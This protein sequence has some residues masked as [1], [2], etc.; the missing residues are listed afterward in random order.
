MVQCTILR[1]YHHHIPK[2]IKNRPIQAWVIYFPSSDF[3][4][5]LASTSHELISCSYYH[6]EQNISDRAWENRSYAHILYFEKYKFE[7]LNALHFSCGTVQL[8]QM[9]SVIIWLG[10]IL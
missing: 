3:H 4:I 7:I 9:Y 8:R 10:I 6:Q 1:K 5:N 2:A